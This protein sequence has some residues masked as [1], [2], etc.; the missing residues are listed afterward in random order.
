MT[1]LKPAAV[2]IGRNESGNRTGVFYFKDD[3][4]EVT[5]STCSVC[6]NDKKSQ[7]SEQS[8]CFRLCLCGPAL[9]RRGGKSF[10]EE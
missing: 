1:P 3:C 6:L 4:A 7:V 9:A 2:R 8:V 5:Y 10:E